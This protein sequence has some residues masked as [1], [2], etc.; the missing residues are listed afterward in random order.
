MTMMMVVV[1]LTVWHLSST[2]TVSLLGVTVLGV[3]I[4]FLML[5]RRITK[6]RGIFG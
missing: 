6:F 3:K 5:S 2:N 1:L 4:V